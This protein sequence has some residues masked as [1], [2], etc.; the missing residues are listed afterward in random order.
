MEMKVATAM[1]CKRQIR[2]KF[3][4]GAGKAIKLVRQEK[5]E[6]TKQR[7]FKPNCNSTGR[8]RRFLIKIRGQAQ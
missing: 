7:L 2:R 8:N 5:L 1:L 3:G 4:W 6:T